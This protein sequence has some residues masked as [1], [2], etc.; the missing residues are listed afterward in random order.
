MRRDIQFRR[1]ETINRCAI[2]DGGLGSFDTIPGGLPSVQR[3]ASI[4]SSPAR[5]TTADGCCRL[6][7]SDISCGRIIRS[8]NEEAA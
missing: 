2:C 6:G 4:A 8:R 5:R 3:S 7:P 1:E